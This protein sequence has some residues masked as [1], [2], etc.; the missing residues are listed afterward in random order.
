MRTF[1]SLAVLAAAAVNTATAADFQSGLQVGDYPFPYYV[2]DVT[3][4]L[5]GTKLCYRCK[6]GAQ[7]VV[8]IFT[9]SM[10]ANVTKLVKQIDEVVGE[11]RDSRMAAFVVVLTDD[12]AAQEASLKKAATDNSIKHTPL[13]VYENA[14]GPSKYRLNEEADVTVLMWSDSDVKVSHAFKAAEL[15]SEAIARVLGD[16]KKILN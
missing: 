10:D 2:S 1:L 13:T 8:N 12:P 14:T 4:P 15:N 7:P 9:R 3:G 11:N 16:T 5:A 6:Y